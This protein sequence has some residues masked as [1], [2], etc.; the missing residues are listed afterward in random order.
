[1]NMNFRDEVYKPLINEILDDVYYR[2]THFRTKI[3]LLRHYLEIVVRRLVDYPVNKSMTIGAFDIKELLSEI[4]SEV[5]ITDKYLQKTISKTNRLLNKYNHTEHLLGAKKED[6]DKAENLVFSV[7]SLNFII[8]FMKNEF[9]LNVHDMESFS[10]LPPII[11]LKVLEYLYIEGTENLLLIHKYLLAILK[12]KNKE[13]AI[14]WIKKRKMQLQK[15]STISD[16]YNFDKYLV[17]GEKK[18]GKK[19][20]NMYEHLI[21]AVEY[22]SDQRDS[23]EALVY[24]T[25]EQAAQA[26]DRVCCDERALATFNK[27][28]QIKEVIEFLFIGRK[29]QPHKKAP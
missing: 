22:V 10:I 1:M 5:G 14:Q 4:E 9:G 19:H 18:F 26:Y 29:S 24:S 15:I 23:K 11:R 7:I 3:S 27:A 21:F 2:K 12:S 25:F 6:F 28:I 20:K 13:V 16:K 8:Y 17:A